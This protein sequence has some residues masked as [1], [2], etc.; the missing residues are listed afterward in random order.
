MKQKVNH[1]RSKQ[2]RKTLRLKNFFKRV[3]DKRFEKK[4]EA[5]KPKGT[6]VYGKAA[7][8]AIKVDAS[9]NRNNHHGRFLNQRQKRKIAA[10]NR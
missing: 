9:F 7:S 4:M 2:R 1:A 3:M 10:Q 8:N 6:T 5:L